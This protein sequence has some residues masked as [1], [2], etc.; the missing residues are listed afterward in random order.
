MSESPI[1]FILA[2]QSNMCGRARGSD[3]EK[4]L[5][6][7][8]PEVQMV[9]SNDLNM[10]HPSISAD[11][12]DLS[13]QPN[14][15]SKTS[16]GPEISLG[17]KLAA[18]LKRPIYFIKFALGSTNLYANWDPNGRTI[19]TSGKNYYGDF[20]I[21]V[22]KWKEVLKLQYPDIEFGGIFW[23]Q[24]EGDAL[25]KRFARTYEQ[26]LKEFFKCLREKFGPCPIVTGFIKWP[27]NFRQEVNL[28]IEN[29]AKNDDQIFTVDTSDLT[30]IAFTYDPQ[31]YNPHFDAKSLLT[32]GERM[33]DAYLN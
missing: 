24:G 14:F 5:Q 2:G 32:L 16:F 7:P 21:Y 25:D 4:E 27:A 22:L 9:W 1:Y 11:W 23:M 15:H 26:N 29:V 20:I 12:Q 13:P 30:P 31:H 17:R 8:F 18:V 10:K 19:R 6:A 3:L 28:A 33:A